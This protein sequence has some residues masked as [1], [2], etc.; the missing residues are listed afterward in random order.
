M[1]LS[2]INERR[3]HW[4]YEGI[5]DAPVVGESR[6]RRWELVGTWRNTLIEAGGGRM[7]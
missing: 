1:A 7:G 4:F 6:M 2:C 5:I 3:V